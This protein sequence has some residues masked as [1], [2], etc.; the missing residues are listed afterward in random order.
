VFII[1]R[2]TRPVRFAGWV[3]VDLLVLFG[4]IGVTKPAVG[5]AGLGAVLILSSMLVLANHRTIWENYQKNYKKFGTGGLWTKPNPIIYRLN[6][7]L[8]WPLIFILGL[9]SIYAAYMVG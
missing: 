2:H 7:Y 9:A 1:R 8:V 6:A 5:L 3:F 4:V